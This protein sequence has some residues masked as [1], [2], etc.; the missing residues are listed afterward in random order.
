MNISDVKRKATPI[1]RSYG[2]KRASVFGSTSR[3]DATA[4]SDVDLLVS[5]GKPMGMISYV[6]F[7]AELESVLGK[8]VDI[9]SERNVPQSLRSR[10]L[11]DATE[12]Y[13][14]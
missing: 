11:A 4:Q 9:M 8:D 14:A 7:I 10:V 5:F 13:A 1:L 3:G 12:I 6:R 2:I